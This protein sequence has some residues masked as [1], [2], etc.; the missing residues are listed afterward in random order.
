[1]LVSEGAAL[2]LRLPE[3]NHHRQEEEG[4]HPLVPVQRVDLFMLVSED[5]TALCRQH[6]PRLEETCLQQ[7]EGRHPLLVQRVVLFM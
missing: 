6:H 7:Q 4:Q 5:N 2:C 1:M 3:D